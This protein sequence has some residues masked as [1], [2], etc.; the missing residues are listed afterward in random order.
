MTF[1]LAVR[2]LRR[3]LAEIP[4]VALDVLREPILSRLDQL[5]QLVILV[6]DDPCEN[7]VDCL[8]VVADDSLSTERQAVLHALE[9]VLGSPYEWMEFVVGLGRGGKVFL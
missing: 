3:V 4:E 6:V 5:V 8:R 9:V 2:V 1:E 7:A